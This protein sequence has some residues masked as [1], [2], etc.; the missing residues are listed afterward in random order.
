MSVFKHVTLVVTTRNRPTVLLETLDSVYRQN[1]GVR[2]VVVDD[3]STDNTA[4]VVRK[5]NALY[6]VA[7]RPMRYGKVWPGVRNPGHAMNVGLRAVKTGITILQSDDV[8]HSPNTIEKL[9]IVT[10]GTVHIP[11]ILGVDGSGNVTREIIGPNARH[12]RFTLAATHTNNFRKIG[13]CDEDFIHF[14]HEDAWMELCLIR[15]LGIIPVFNPDIRVHHKDHF[16]EASEWDGKLTRLQY[17]YKVSL[18]ERGLIPYCSAGGPW[19]LLEH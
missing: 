14:G 1:T 15:G 8:I 19:E 7:K 17:D 2:V 3:D 5:F 4:E 16:V 13:G 9:S 12:L 10:P 6:L 18:A 11:T